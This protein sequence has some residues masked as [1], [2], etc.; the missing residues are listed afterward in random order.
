M[1]FRSTFGGPLATVGRPLLRLRKAKNTVFFVSYEQSKTFDSAL[2][3]TLVPVAQNDRY[4]LPP[5][6]SLDQR[7]VEEAEPPI[8]AAEVAPFISSLNTP[9]TNTS[10]TARVDHQFS[11]TH[12]GS[13]VYQTG[14]LVNLRQFGGGNRLADA[15]QARNHNSDAISYSD[16]LV[17]SS[18]VVNQLRFQ[19]SQ[20]A[21][22]FKTSAGNKP[23]VL[24]TLNDPSL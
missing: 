10:I 4:P 15:L 13:V 24:I 12:N 2:V 3:D 7:R 11:E 20:L 5:P 21:P 22:S 17:L 14:R 18:Q 16:N 1:L 9:L 6:T 23:V 8:L 19:Y